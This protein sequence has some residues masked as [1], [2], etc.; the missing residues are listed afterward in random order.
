MLQEHPIQ[1][2]GCP[3]F[4]CDW[5]IFIEIYKEKLTCNFDEFCAVDQPQEKQHLFTDDEEDQF[6]EF[7]NNQTTYKK[8]LENYSETNTASLNLPYFVIVVLLCSLLFNAM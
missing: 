8:R 4:L 5:D 2:E 6:S 1:L 7:D 3:D